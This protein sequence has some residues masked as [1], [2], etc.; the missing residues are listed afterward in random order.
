MVMCPS[1]S[2][3]AGASL[4][5]GRPRQDSEQ[6][7]G[8]H[9][10]TRKLVEAKDSRYSHGGQMHDPAS[11]GPGSGCTRRVD[12]EWGVNEQGGK[13]AAGSGLRYRCPD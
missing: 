11:T 13:G 6:P 3:R 8:I 4:A 1:T 12:L 10:G 7:H 9:G 2:Q 5:E